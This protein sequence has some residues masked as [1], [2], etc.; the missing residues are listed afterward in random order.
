MR[1]EQMRSHFMII[2]MCSVTSQ[3][4]IDFI[5]AT[6]AILVDGDD[7]NND[8]CLTWMFFLDCLFDYFSLFNVINFLSQNINKKY[9]QIKWL[10]QSSISKANTGIHVENSTKSLENVSEM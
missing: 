4:A 1:F 3:C 8:G 2:V 7:H 6:D 10:Q 5:V 9:N